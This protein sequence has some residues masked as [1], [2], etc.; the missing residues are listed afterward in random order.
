MKMPNGLTDQYMANILTY[1]SNT[2]LKTI[3]E[4]SEILKYSEKYEKCAWEILTRSYLL[5]KTSATRPSRHRQHRQCGNASSHSIARY[6][7]IL[8]G[9][10]LGISKRWWNETGGTLCRIV[11]LCRGNW[12]RPKACSWHVVASC[13]VQCGWAQVSWNLWRSFKWSILNLHEVSSTSSGS[14]LFG[15]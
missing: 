14:D 11:S 10:L 9:G 12:C 13:V 5:V 8:S 7:P 1:Y 2:S 15:V 6:V 3:E 4:H